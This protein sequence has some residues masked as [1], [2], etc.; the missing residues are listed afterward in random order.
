MS[1]NK[2]KQLGPEESYKDSKL[3]VGWIP[4]RL[5]RPQLGYYLP[6]VGSSIQHTNSL[7]YATLEALTPLS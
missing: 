1:T 6:L 7:K 3:R 4:I 5:S 2:F